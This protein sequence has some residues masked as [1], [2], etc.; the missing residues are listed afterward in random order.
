MCPYKRITLLSA[1]SIGDKLF[2]LTIDSEV[3]SF[4]R[5]S[6]DIRS[7]LASFRLGAA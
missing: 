1:A 7:A 5:Y 3:N 2:T 4:Q 6:K